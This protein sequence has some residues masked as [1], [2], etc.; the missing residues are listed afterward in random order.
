MQ[1]KK[2]YFYYT[3]THF[4]FF[5]LLAVLTFFVLRPLQQTLRERMVSLR[6]YII[7]RTEDFFGFRI[8][9]ASTGPSLFG[10]LDIKDIRIWENS[11]DA[12]PSRYPLI[13]ISRFRVSYSLFAILRGDIPASVRGIYLDRPLISLDALNLEKYR[14]IAA[15]LQ[16]EGEN[17]VTAD[18]AGDWAG[19]LPGDIMV[20]IR[21]G[22]CA[23][24]LGESSASLRGL[25]FDT[26]IAND[27]IELRG[28]WIAGLS[29]SYL[30]DKNFAVAMAGRVSGEYDLAGRKGSITLNVPS[31][32]G[33]YFNIRAVNF[34]V[35]LDSEGLGIRKIPDSSPFSLSLDYAFASGRVSAEFR[36]DNFSPREIMVLSGDRRDYN[37]Y[38]ALTTTGSA[39]FEADG[40]GRIGYRVDLSGDLG[41]NFSTG[42]SNYAIKGSGDEKQ[43]YFDELLLAFAHGSLGY[44]GNLQYSPLEPNGVITVSDFSISGDS[45]LNGELTVSGS[46]SHVDIFSDSFSLGGVFLSALDL[47]FIRGEEGLSFGLSALRFRDVES[48]EDVSLSEISLD[49]TLNYSP[50]ELQTSLG[51]DSFS[52]MD[53]LEIMRPFGKVPEFSAPAAAAIGGTSISTEIF[54][55]TDFSQISYN[56]P[57][58]VIA[59]QGRTELLALISLSGTDR[60]F[61]ISEGSIVWP[62]GG[63]NITGSADFSNIDDVSFSVSA[64][65]Q[66]QTYYLE[67]LFLDQNSFSVTGSYG[68]SAYAVINPFGGF[69]AYFEVDSIPIP[70]NDQFARFST[71]ISVR[72]DNPDSWYA[73]LDRFEV[74]D[75]ATPVSLSSS[76]RVS[77]IAD[78]EG[79]QLR[80]LYFDDGR[81]ALWGEADF[82]W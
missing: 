18:K 30:F 70:I 58:L 57:Q 45:P 75:L 52:V 36:A 62:G 48:W 69:S 49:G 59:Y 44:S 29:L 81:G 79:A 50:L 51:F 12:P 60:R 10:F 80:D 43:A 26:R 74:V 8:E 27:K 56:I 13:S 76:I 25:N 61:D 28:K 21:R 41:Q 35:L 17:A 40:E 11:G 6:D 46:G 37:R 64:S 68:L 1:A 33:E 19:L 7:T 53:I 38:L 78:Q 5:L 63:S 3:A 77:G 72:Y 2:N 42:L 31:A 23:I 39:S 65:W 32:A 15:K 20:R 54:I 73:D 9:Y 71:F 67:G 55:T 22:E 82:S 47:E 16:G 4:L 14:N 66:E 34:E 24:R